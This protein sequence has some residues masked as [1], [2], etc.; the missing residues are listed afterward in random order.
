MRSED[1]RMS[2]Q[3]MYAAKVETITLFFGGI[4][5]TFQPAPQEIIWTMSLASIQN[6]FY[7]ASTRPDTCIFGN[8]GNVGVMSNIFHYWTIL[9]YRPYTKFIVKERWLLGDLFSWRTFLIW[10]MMKKCWIKSDHNFLRAIALI[11]NSF[12]NSCSV[13]R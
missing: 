8:K 4:H 3:Q 2:W 10:K 1:K 7:T 12:D 13:E 9:N 5:P 11:C 6:C